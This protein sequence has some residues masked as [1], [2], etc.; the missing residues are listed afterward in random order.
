MAEYL[1]CRHESALVP[2]KE[3]GGLNVERLLWTHGGRIDTFKRSV[4]PETWACV[5]LYLPGDAGVSDG[6]QAGILWT[7]SHQVHQAPE[8]SESAED[9]VLL[10][11][12][13]GETCTHTQLNHITKRYKQVYYW[14]YILYMIM[15]TQSITDDVAVQ[16]GTCVDNDVIIMV[17]SQYSRVTVQLL[18]LIR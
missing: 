14:L 10:P 18:L 2:L 12:P 13:K 5:F 8:D 16:T 4:S 11:G 17:T 9:P 3:D 6:V 1:A 15:S 7:G